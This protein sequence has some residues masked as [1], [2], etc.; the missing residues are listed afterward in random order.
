VGGASGQSGGYLARTLSGW[1]AGSTQEKKN[2]GLRKGAMRMAALLGGGLA[3]EER[4]TIMKYEDRA[5][6]ML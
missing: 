3:G 2:G 4:D 1:A 5:K 6:G